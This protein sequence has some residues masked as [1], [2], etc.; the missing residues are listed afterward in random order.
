MASWFGGAAP[1]ANPQQR[2]FGPTEN[3][4]MKLSLQREGYMKVC[5]VLFLQGPHIPV[6]ALK[7]AVRQLQNRHP[8]LRSRLQN[9][10]ATPETFLMEEN[11]NVQLT[12]R[13]IARDRNESREF[14]RREYRQ[15]EKQVP[16]VGEPLVEFWLLQV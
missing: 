4:V 14:W 16:R 12:I 10:P 8:F 15:R 11:E 6:E 3:A 2:L 5:E 9:N 13:E 7:S 1:V